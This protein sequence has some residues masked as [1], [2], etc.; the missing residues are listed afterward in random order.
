M[1]SS[2]APVSCIILA[3]G[4]GKR[5]GGSDKGLLPYRNMPLI[6]HVIDAIKLQV[7]DIVISANRNIDVYSQYTNTVINDSSD[8]YR[9]P[10]AGIAA[11]LP[12]CQ[13]ELILIVACDMPAL[14][15][16]L[17]RR[18]TSGMVHKSI[19]IATVDSHHQLAMLINGS[20]LESIQQHLN[21]NQ[22]RLI[23]W[24][25]SVPYATVSFDHAAQAFV[26]LNRLTD[27]K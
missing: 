20:L 7:D 9:G 5:A 13:H 14:P 19:S 3:G 26:N 11:C 8:D 15:D 4:E 23:Q 17:V 27:T 21:D 16:D 1:N 22:L 12:H 24:V 6:E 18:L 2:P 25:E 10:L